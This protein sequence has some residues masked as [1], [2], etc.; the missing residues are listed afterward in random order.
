MMAAAMPAEM[1]YWLEIIEPLPD[2]TAATGLIS[3]ISIG[4]A[5]EAT[6]RERL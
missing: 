2:D 3:T 5:I 6:Q 1:R 4:S